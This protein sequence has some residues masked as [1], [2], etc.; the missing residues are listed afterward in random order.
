MDPLLFSYLGKTVTF[1]GA[2]RLPDAEGMALRHPVWRG[3]HECSIC[4]L[5]ADQATD[6]AA[7]ALLRDRRFL[8]GASVCEVGCG[9]GVLAVLAARLGASR[10]LGID[11]DLKALA[12][13]R[14]TAAANGVSVELCRGDLLASVRGRFD[15]LIANLPQKPVLRGTRLPLGQDGGL[16]GD[17]L[18]RRFLPQA[19]RRLGPGGRLYFFVHT[20][21][22]PEMFARLAKSF[23]V[24]V[25]F[26]RRR[27][28]APGE[29][30]QALV[31]H[32]MGLAAKGRALIHP[33]PHRPGWHTFYAMQVVGVRRAAGERPTRSSRPAAPSPP[34]RPP[35]PRAPGP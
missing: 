35:G 2:R 6:L 18:L 26:W 7:R 8:K 13:A 27:H 10:V 19:A 30:P 3:I 17:A 16:R 22:P 9:T 14:R 31:D 1:H 28:V 15:V 5:R 4:G 25:A 34:P 20:L 29:Y 23:R 12:L 33:R 21:T 11:C 24:E 32:W